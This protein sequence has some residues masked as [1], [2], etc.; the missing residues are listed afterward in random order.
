MGFRNRNNPNGQPNAVLNNQNANTSKVIPGASILTPALG[1]VLVQ[2]GLAQNSGIN[3]SQNNANFQ[4]PNSIGMGSTNLNNSMGGPGSYNPNLNNSLNS[5]N[6]NSNLNNSMG[7]PGN[8]NNP[9]LND[10]GQNSSNYGYPARQASNQ[11][12][13]ETVTYNK[14][15]N[16]NQSLPRSNSN[17]LGE[18]V[19]YDQRNSIGSYNNNYQR[20]NSMG[21]NPS[22]STS[23]PYNNSSNTGG[24]FILSDNTN[25]VLD[26][27]NRDTVYSRSNSFGSQN[28]ANLVY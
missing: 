18:T 27:R 6:Y 16:Y 10:F 21:Y 11:Y 23:V 26:P 20:T 22:G 28:Q 3:Q 15:N 8:Y 17:Q 25:T 4:N 19:T 14:Q 13:G 2:Q 9:P 24:D 7:G 1:N 5:G 12:G